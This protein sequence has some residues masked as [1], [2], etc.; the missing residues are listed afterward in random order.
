MTNPASEAGRRA[1]AAVGSGDREAWLSSY[2]DDAV[3][4]D[5]VGGSP[6]DPEG[7]GIAGR[8]ELERFWD[9]TIAPNEISFD[10]RE[11]HAAGDEAAFV[12]TVSAKFPTGNTV[13][14]DGVFIYAVD[15]Q[16]RI[17]TLRGYWDLAVVLAAFS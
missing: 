5:P 9:L 7:K 14:Y 11:V 4:H 3:L 16:G 15:D 8:T 1:M 2:S 6:L 17:E 12:A 10:V 13:T